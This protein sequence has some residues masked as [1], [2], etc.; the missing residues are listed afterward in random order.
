MMKQLWNIY[1][2]FALFLL[3]TVPAFTAEDLWAPACRGA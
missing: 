2:L 1:T 3:V